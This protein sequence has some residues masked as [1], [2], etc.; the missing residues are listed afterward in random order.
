MTDSPLF[1]TAALNHHLRGEE[2]SEILRLSPTW[3]WAI[4]GTVAGLLV[5]ALGLAFFGRVEVHGRGQGILRGAGGVRTLQAQVSG[6][7]R[8]VFVHPGQSLR[9]GELLA[10]LDTASLQGQLLEAERQI[11]ILEIEAQGLGAR[12][13]AHFFAQESSLRQRMKT[14][15]EQT[16]SLAESVKLYE[17][18]TIANQKLHQEQL[19][20]VMALED[21]RESL[22]QA[23]RQLMSNQ[24]ALAAAEQE[25]AGLTQRRDEDQ[26]RR[27]R[28]LQIARTR[29]DALAFALTQT[30]ILAP[31]DGILEG[32][33]S[34][35]GD[36][37]QVGQVLGRLLPSRTLLQAVAFLPEKDRAFVKVGDAVKVELEQYPYGEFGTLKGRITRIGEDLAAPQEVKEALGD[38]API[39]KPLIRV[40]LELSPTLNPKVILR[41]GMLLQARFTLRR[42]RP[43]T[44]FLEPLRR[45]LD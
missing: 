42:Q 32:M 43:I 16:T 34:R 24:Q 18:K 20:S 3:T 7:L 36:S 27:S 40:E 22:A 9:K 2:S 11:Q 31:E 30:K 26:G 44:L 13:E 5:I 29:R 12:S 33:L 1:R 14:L 21:A 25:L 17:R 10:E 41:A 8:T 19:V 4:T 39:D 15:E 38:G 23:R 35:P 45:W 28:E 37:I 6:T